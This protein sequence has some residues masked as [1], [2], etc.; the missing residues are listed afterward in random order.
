MSY[1]QDRDFSYISDIVCIDHFEPFLLAFRLLWFASIPRN[2]LL[3][4][5]LAPKSLHVHHL[6]PETERNTVILL[7]KFKFAQNIY[8]TYHF[9]KGKSVLESWITTFLRD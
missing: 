6:K 8:I 1:D 9:A 5:A 7:K 2:F 4:K 3:S